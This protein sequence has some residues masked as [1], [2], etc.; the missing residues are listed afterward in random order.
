[1]KNRT[2]ERLLQ[3]IVGTKGEMLNYYSDKGIQYL[4]FR[5]IAMWRNDSKIVVDDY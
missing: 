5:N 2:M 4:D 1:M 3:V